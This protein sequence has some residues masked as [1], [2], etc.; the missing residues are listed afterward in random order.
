VIN[1][2]IDKARRIFGRITSYT[3][4]RVALTTD[5]SFLVVLS[6]I[7]L[8]FVSTDRFDHRI[9]SLRPIFAEAR[10]QELVGELRA[11]FVQH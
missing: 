9:A 3:L 6:T 10:F 7:F 8:G 5:M 4:Y 1:S 2:A 11:D